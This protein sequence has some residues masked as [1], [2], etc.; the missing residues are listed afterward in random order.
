VPQ[1]V[2]ECFTIIML[3]QHYSTVFKLYFPLLSQ[4][5]NKQ[6][7]VLNNEEYLD[8]YFLDFNIYFHSW[9]KIRINFSKFKIWK[10]EVLFKSLN[11]NY[12]FL[13]NNKLNFK[14]FYLYTFNF[15]NCVVHE[16]IYVFSHIK[17][18]IK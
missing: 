1:S 8:T 13:N 5:D 15:I 3:P 17:M 10:F 11:Q 12:R 2:L 7:E 4:M 9:R 18:I 16:L 14:N 6:L